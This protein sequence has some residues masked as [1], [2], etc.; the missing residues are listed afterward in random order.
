M[1][2][3]TSTTRLLDPYLTTVNPMWHSDPRG[4]ITAV[5][6]LTARAVAIRIR[7]NRAWRGHRAGQHVTLGIEIDGVRHHRCYSITSAER[8]GR[9]GSIE[10]AVQSVDGGL[11]SN[12][13]RT[14]ARAGD[15]VVLSQADGDFVLPTFVPDRLL[16]VTGGSG[17]TPIIGMLRTLAERPPHSDVVV[18]HHAPAAADTMFAAELAVR[19]AT[20]RVTVHVSHTRQGGRRLDAHRLDE[21]C[22]DWRD[23]ETFVCGPASLVGFATEHWADHG[24]LDRLHLERFSLVMPAIADDQR[25]AG[26]V[27][28][29]FTRSNVVTAT[30]EATTLLDAAEAGGVVA[31]YGCR[32]GV[33]HTCSTRLV[34]GCARDLRTGRVVDAGT[35]VQ[36]C[37]SVP[38]G[39]VALDL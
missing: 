15:V 18:L 28:A 30:T 29:A 16:F 12:H 4:T 39:D 22:P 26:T 1:I 19:E 36:L 21:L 23:R 2:S 11:V 32:S 31:P 9:G 6:P 27:S 33:C 3:L 14:H 25:P 13:L 24:L 7:T 34:S 35:H 10:I 38:A 5:T 37:V 20:G 17:V 8:A